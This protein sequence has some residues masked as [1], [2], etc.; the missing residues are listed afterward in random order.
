MGAACFLGDGTFG[1]LFK[2]LLI[3]GISSDSLSFSEVH[4]VEEEIA[5]AGCFL[6]PFEVRLVLQDSL[7]F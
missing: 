4:S 6:G 5:E 7:A 1:A 2:K 3:L